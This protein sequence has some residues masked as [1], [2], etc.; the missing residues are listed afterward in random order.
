MS[1]GLA[2]HPPKEAN[3]SM[4]RLS[5]FIFKVQTATRRYLDPY[6]SPPLR[7]SKKPLSDDNVRDFMSA[8]ER[9]ELQIW[10]EIEDLLDHLKIAYPVTVRAVRKNIR[11]L[12]KKAYQ[13]GLSWGKK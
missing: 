12:R 1:Y 6:E 10:A 9:R 2:I 7:S 8:A 4:S 11:W 3:G 13:N 5:E